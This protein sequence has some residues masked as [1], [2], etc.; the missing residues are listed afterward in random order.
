[1]SIKRI[2]TRD[3]AKHL[4]LHYTT[5]AEALRNSPRISAKTRARVNAAAKDLDYKPDPILN[6]LNAY[7][8]NGKTDRRLATIA[9]IN[10]Y[11]KEHLKIGFT[12][13]CFLG[14]GERVNELGY[15]LEKFWI[16]S[17]QMSHKRA[18]DILVARGIKGVLVP[19]LDERVKTL[20]LAW[21]NF[22]AVQLGYSLRDSNL[23]L[24][25]ADQV[26]NT[27][28][29]FRFL[30]R[31][32]FKRIGLACPRWINQ[33]VN[34]GFVS[35]FL[36]AHQEYLPDTKP[37]PLFQKDLG[38]DTE[39]EFIEWIK[40]HKLE[41]LIVHRNDDYESVL[42]KAGIRVPED[43]SLAWLTLFNRNSH[44][45]GIYENGELVG[46][47]GINLLVAMINRG[48]YGPSIPR[49]E[50]LLHGT[51]VVGRTIQLP[52]SAGEIHK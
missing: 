45:C 31:A 13:D 17:P 52:E 22:S 30:T 42:S 38:E 23:P 29:L 51:L 7:R 48:E 3:I 5:V 35:G 32:G 33:R 40:H 19:P 10:T 20:D 25:S 16:N 2:T 49:S 44:R 12:H 36:G 11:E 21:E 47:H 50:L 24:V 26:G 39:H 27:R 46:R 37:F 9:W 15:K 34:T 8:C 1:M 14:T 18:S 4:G 6:A 43:I 28:R 41:A